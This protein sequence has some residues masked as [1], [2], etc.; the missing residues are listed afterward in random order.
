MKHF[1]KTLLLFILLFSLNK[2]WSQCSTMSVSADSIT[3][4]K[5]YNDSSGAVRLHITS[6]WP[7]YRILVDSGTLYS[8]TIITPDTLVRIGRLRAGTHTILIIDSFGCR[9][10]VTFTL[11]ESFFDVTIDSVVNYRCYNSTNTG[12]F[13]INIFSSFPRYSIYINSTSPTLITNSTSVV[14]TG[15]ATGTYRVVVIDSM[16]CKDSLNVTITAPTRISPTASPVDIP[17]GGGS[18][19]SVTIT[20]TGGTPGFQYALVGRTPYQS[21]NSFGSLPVGNFVAVV[22]DTNGCFD[23]V[24]FSINQ[25]CSLVPFNIT[26]RDSICNG[27]CATILTSLP[28]L[29]KTTSYTVSSIPYVASLPCEGAGVEAPGSIELD[30]IHSTIVPIGF[31]FCFFG[32]TYSQCVMSANGYI[33]F[34]TAL[35]GTFSP[36]SFTA[37]AALPSSVVTQIRN[38]ILGPYHDIDPSVSYSPTYVTYQTIGVAPWRAFIVKYSNV[39]MF[40][41]TSLRHTSKIVIYE[42][43][44]II[45]IYITNKPLCTGWNGGRAIE[46]IQNATGTVG[47]AVPGRNATVWTAVN[48]AWR[49]TPSG[50]NI[51]VNIYWYPV[52]SPGAPIALNDTAT[53]CPSLSGPFPTN[54]KYYARAVILDSCTLA[55]SRID[56]ISLYDTTTVWVI[57][58]YVT[59]I[60]RSDTLFCEQD[61]LRL[62]AGSG[63]VQHSWTP[64]P[65]NPTR[66]RWVYTPGAY[67]CFKFTD[68]DRCFL[69]SVAFRVY[70]SSPL[71]ASVRT[72]IPVRCHGDSSGVII[73]Q[74]V[75]NKGPVRYGLDGAT[76]IIGDTIRNIRAGGHFVIATDSVGCRDSVYF[77]MI[78]PAALSITLDSLIPPS[79]FAFADGRIQ[80]TASGGRSPYTYFWNTASG[81]NRYTVA[82]AGVNF[83]Q[84][85]DSSLCVLSDTFI[86]TQPSPLI[87]DSIL[88]DSTLC[89]GS[90]NGSAQVFASGATP[91]SHGYNYTWSNASTVSNP[92]SLLAGLYF[93]TVRDSNSCSVVDSVTVFQPTRVTALISGITGITC[94]NGSNGIILLN[95]SGGSSGYEYSLDGGISYS[96]LTVRSGFS[97]GLQTIR[98]RDYHGCT[99]DTSYTFTNPMRILPTVVITQP[100]ACVGASNGFVL[101]DPTNGSAPYQYS[102]DKIVW[103]TSDTLRGFVQGS[104]MAYVLDSNNCIDSIPFTIGRVTPLSIRLD[105]SNVTCHNGSDGSISATVLGGTLNYQYSLNGS[106]YVTSNMFASL[107]QG[108]YYVRVRDT[109]NCMISDTIHVTQPPRILPTVALTHITCFGYNN[110]QVSIT[111]TNGSSPF[112][113][114]VD[115][116]GYGS[117]ATIGSLTPGLHRA[118]VRDRYLCVDSIDFTI[119]QPLGMNITVS[120]LRNVSCNGGNNGMIRISVSN[121]TRPYTYAWS[122]GSIFDSASTLIAGTYYVTVSDS[123]GC[124]L[125]DT[126]TISQPPILSGVLSKVDVLCYGAATGTA[127]ITPSGGTTPYTYLW[128]DALAQTTATA[129]ALVAGTYTVTVTDFLGCTYNNSIT[130]NQPD[131]THLTYTL[132]NVSCFS[133]SNGQINATMTGGIFPYQYNI[134]GA[135]QPSGLFSGLT[136]GTYT[137]TSR[138]FNNCTKSVTITITQPLRINP[139]ISS[140]SPVTCNGGANGFVVV[141]PTNGIAPYQYSINNILY[142][143]SDTL[144]DLSAG[145]YR[146]YVQDSTGCIDSVN[147]TITQPAAIILDI[148]LSQNKCHNDNTGAITI[149]PRGGTTPYNYSIDGGSTLVSSNSFSSLVAGTYNVYIIDDKGCTASSNVTLNNPSLFTINASG[150]D[151]QCWDSDNGKIII[152]PVGGTP[153]YVSYEYS[154]NNVVFEPGTSSTILDLSAG[155]YYVRAYDANGCM[156][157]D[158][159]VIG[160]PPVDTFAFSIDSTSCYGAQYLDGS[161]IVSA[162]ANP[163]Y[164]WTID[165]GPIQNHGIFYGLGAGPHTIIAANSNGCIDTL[166]QYVPFPPP[167]IVDMIPDTVFLELGGS[168]QVNVNVQNAINPTYLWNTL[169]GL[170]CIDC[171][172]PIVSPHLDMVY[173]IRVYDHSHPLNVNECYGDATLYVFVEQ[174]EKSYVPNAFTPANTDGINDILYVYGEG[175]KKLRFVVFDRYGELL[176]ESDRQSKGWDGTYK[177]KLLEPGVYIYSIEAEYLDNKRETYQGSVTLIR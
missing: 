23:T 41:C 106:S 85:F 35:A 162:L 53:L 80:I 90:S 177:G 159:S 124:T 145:S 139:T 131:S 114:A 14:R 174:H 51:P 8:R 117:S 26:D 126:F 10:T 89:F 11:T 65:S 87:I 125:S 30:D 2:A 98:V 40:S 39:P 129:T 47:Y 153:P 111:P 19:G 61:S 37:A 6:T 32:N 94:N 54:I 5:C 136:A 77:V 71:D 12:S 119:N 22:R 107:T 173:T 116:S 96:S 155:Y 78:E 27:T 64:L 20:P 34:N 50:P 63:G 92:G 175:I 24:R 171:P 168:Q 31:D 1:Y 105:S 84:V 163:P 45:D 110:G 42:T 137:L 58:A 49:F 60:F 7:R 118:Y 142:Q 73:M 150:I 148:V 28:V 104:Y 164:T 167:V 157:T 169:Q 102:K 152:L 3:N 100:E 79:C 160:R 46:G 13:R 143:V 133:G 52:V 165:G 108:M 122:S 55:A 158:T 68:I 44:N 138:D 66:Y 112:S 140:N 29:N 21:S 132:Q 15:L 88:A 62:D 172:N 141:N 67:T 144:K 120:A 151:V 70:E 128:S 154:Q 134:G 101:I 57:G 76:P 99:D 25:S 149:T 130:I 72:T 91:Y 95:A 33:T 170:S 147:F 93:V 16:G 74:S 48:D 109:N 83:V 156:A 18:I 56:S 135:W 121:G 36:W 43:T 17:F 75:G 9:D 123:N 176:F 82:T 146:A 97:A 59:P 103:Q 127:T 115:A 81:T 69:D 161:I 86:L 38:A 4:L 113:Y 166:V